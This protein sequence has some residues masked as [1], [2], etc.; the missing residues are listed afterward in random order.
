MEL[1][2]GI[3]ED[4]LD[5]LKIGR[6]RVRI[7]GL[8]STEQGDFS[9]VK[10]EHLPWS[11][12]MGGTQFGL[13]AGVGCSSIL[14]IG[15]WVWVTLDHENP[16]KPIIIGTIIGNNTTTS[17]GAKRT[18]S[19]MHELAQDSYTYVQTIETDSGHLMTLDDTPQNENI[20]LTHRTGSSILIDKDGNIFVNGVANIQYDIAGNATWNIAGNQTTN[21]QGATNHT[22]AGDTTV[23]A[24]NIYLN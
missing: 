12:I 20:K 21:V 8:H 5:P 2:R 13:I 10:T 7:I 15:T 22:T 24:A 11:E 6:V 1:Y 14:R 16:N 3:V 9:H 18:G 19:D 23:N 4:N 17:G